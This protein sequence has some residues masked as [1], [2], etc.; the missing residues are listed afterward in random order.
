MRFYLYVATPLAINSSLHTLYILKAVALWSSSNPE[1]K[2]AVFGTTEHNCVNIAPIAWATYTI[3]EPRHA[4]SN[5]L[6]F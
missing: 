1:V 4:I 5:D 3:N 6:T 2:V